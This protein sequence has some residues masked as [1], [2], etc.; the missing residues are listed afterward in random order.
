M[1]KWLPASGIWLTM[2]TAAVA[3]EPF[4]RATVETDGKILPGQQV[5][6]TVDVFVPDFFTSPPQFPLF[7][8][9]DAIVTLPDGRALN[10]VERIDG[11][12][13]SGI[14]RIYAIIPESSGTFALP[15][16]KIPLGYSQNGRPLAGEVSLPPTSIQV[17]APSAGVG[18]SLTFAARDLTITQSFD[19]EP[20]AMKVGDALVRTVT[21]FAKDTQAMMMPAVAFAQP[22]GL[23]MYV[24]APKIADGIEAAD[25]TT[26]STRTE[27]ITYVAQSV[28][29]FEIPEITYPW[30]DVETHKP[31]N[32]IVGAATVSVAAAPGISSEIVPVIVDKNEAAGAPS[33][34]R[35]KLVRAALLVTAVGLLAWLAWG[36]V[37]KRRTWWVA[38]NQ[39]KPRIQ[40][41]RLAALLGSIQNDDYIVIYRAL[42]IWTGSR[43]FRSIAA[44][45]STM[46]DPEIGH[47]IG[48]LER[49]L[50]GAGAD[51]IDIDRVELS[52]MIKSE[53]QQSGPRRVDTS[54]L[55]ELNPRSNLASQ[56]NSLRHLA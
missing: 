12:Q 46:Q 44:W 13:Y 33:S 36:L 24:K 37:R 27:T 29:K 11:V 5:L 15:P 25:R 2:V 20:S 9:P 4:A 30:L 48:I 38:Y 53:V 22:S 8:I 6:V 17:S 7:D 49:K 26:G 42:D 52:R 50:F 55:P 47:Q 16:F 28:G 19:R 18:P 10:K 35:K 23:T 32:A 39:T 51:P 43:G 31:T 21:I 34:V 45:V 3:G 41:R 14:S 1:R 54:S 56:Q 40:K